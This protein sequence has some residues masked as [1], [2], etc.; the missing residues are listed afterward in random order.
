[1]TGQL[2]ARSTKDTCR[3]CESKEDYLSIIDY[4]ETVAN[5]KY[6]EAESLFSQYAKENLDTRLKVI[7]A[8]LLRCNRIWT[9]SKL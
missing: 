9:I 1:M 3:K 4:F 2:K 7:E 8:I 6:C 5:V